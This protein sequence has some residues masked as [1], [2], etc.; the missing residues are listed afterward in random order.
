LVQAYAIPFWGSDKSNVKSFIILK[1]CKQKSNDRNRL[2][3][4][5]RPLQWIKRKMF[6][7]ISALMIGM[8]N[9]I[10]EEDNSIY[11]N[12]DKIEQKQKEE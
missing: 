2:N 4:L 10:Y 3:G 8:S 12:Q 7:I 6:L 1:M 11:G 9:A 5:K